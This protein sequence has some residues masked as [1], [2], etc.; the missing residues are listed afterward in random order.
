[1]FGFKVWGGEK[2]VNKKGSGDSKQKKV[3][4]KEGLFHLFSLIIKNKKKLLLCFIKIILKNY[5]KLPMTH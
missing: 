5:K 3:P 4:G 1:M 2:F